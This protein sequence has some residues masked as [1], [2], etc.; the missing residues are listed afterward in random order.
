MFEIK[1]YGGRRMTLRRLGLA[2]GA[3]AVALGLAGSAEA[4]SPKDQ[5]RAWRKAH[6]K[7][8]VGDFSTLLSMPNVATTL[9][10]VQKNADYISGLLQKRGFATQIIDAAPGTPPSVFAELKT[11]GAKR[12]VTFYAHY[13]GQPIGQKG[14]ISTPFTPSMRTALPEAKPVIGRPRRLR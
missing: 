2:A 11:P 3:L 1:A 8:I 10:D 7:E 14:W 9:S 6:E 5:V 4:A 13:D 12:T